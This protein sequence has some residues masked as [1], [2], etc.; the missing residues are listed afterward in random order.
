MT[1]ITRRHLLA[2]AVAGRR[3]PGS[4]YRDPF[5]DGLPDRGAHAAGAATRG[6]PGGARGS[7]IRDLR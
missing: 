1:E 4:G 2:G 6:R 7:G 3:G 5:P